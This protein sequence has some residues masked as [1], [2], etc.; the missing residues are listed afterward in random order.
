MAE[1]RIIVRGRF[2]RCLEVSAIRGRHPCPVP[3]ASRASA[4]QVAIFKSLS[5]T[6]LETGENC[7]PH[8]KSGQDGHAAGKETRF[9][10][11]TGFLGFWRWSARQAQRFHPGTSCL[12]IASIV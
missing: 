8:E 12:T 7:S 4:T 9:R 2:E 6:S 5:P 10:Q 3:F 1:K 11:E